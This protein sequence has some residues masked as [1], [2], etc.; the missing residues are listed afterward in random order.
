MRIF[1]Y[2]FPPD[3]SEGTLMTSIL[4]VKFSLSMCNKVYFRDK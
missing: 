3:P 4:G 1:L 2:F